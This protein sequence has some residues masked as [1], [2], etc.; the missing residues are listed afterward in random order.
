MLRRMLR[1]ILCFVGIHMFH[2]SP[3]REQRFDGGVEVEA[4][5]LFCGVRSP[6]TVWIST[7]D[8]SLLG[9]S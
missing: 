2:L 3:A 8:S 7:D 9:E 6:N 5:C 4:R 1:R